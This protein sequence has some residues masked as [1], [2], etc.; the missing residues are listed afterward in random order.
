MAQARTKK[1]TTKKRTTK[2]KVSKKTSAK[3]KVS[4]KT[5]A[6]AQPKEVSEAAKMWEEIKKRP[7]EAFGLANQRV[8]DHVQM[9]VGGPDTD[10]YVKLAAPALLPSLEATLGNQFEVEALEGFVIIR[11][12]AKTLADQLGPAPAVVV[13]VN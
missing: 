10:L 11:R 8:S 7:M 9:F 4:K 13:K 12:S 6:K 5:T 2:K 3:K 1:K